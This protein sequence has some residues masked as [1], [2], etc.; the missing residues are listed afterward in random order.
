MAPEAK[1][2]Y[3]NAAGSN[4]DSEFLK[5]VNGFLELL[6]KTNFKLTDEVDKY[7]KDVIGKLN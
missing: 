3:M 4:S 6:K 5:I 7:R 2:A 1:E